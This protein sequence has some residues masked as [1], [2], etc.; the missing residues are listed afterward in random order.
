MKRNLMKM[1]TVMLSLVLVIGLFAGCGKDGGTAAGPVKDDGSVVIRVPF[2]SEPSSLD[3]GYGNSSD[4]IC[5]RGMMFEGLVRI[6]DNEVHPGMAESWEVADD[7]V[8]YTFHLRDSNW[9]DGEPVTA[10]DFVYGITR[11]LDPS[12]DAPNG[13]YAWMG[14]YIK[15]GEEFNSGECTAEELGIRAIDDKTLEITAVKNM[16]YFVELMKLPCFYPVREDMGEEYGKEYASSPDKVVCNGPFILTEWEHESKLVFEKNPEYWNA[17]AIN[18]DGV[19][20]Y[21]IGDT[22]TI[23]NMFDN[24]EL[25]IMNT[26]GKE[27]IDKYQES[28]EA[29]FIEG[30]TIWYTVVNTKTDRGEVSKLLQNKNFRQ[31]ISYVLNRDALVEAACGDGSFGITRMIPDLITVQDSTLGELYPYEP[32]STKGD[33]EKAQELFDKALEETGFT[34]DNLPD[35]TLLTFDDERAQDSAEIIQAQL[36]EAFGLNVIMDTQTYSARVEKEN[37]GDYDLCI[38]N[39]APDYN[40]P[41]TFLECYESNN[42]YNMYFGGLQNAEYDEIIAFCNATDDMKARADK[43]FEAEQM[44]VDEMVGIPLFQTAGYWGMKTYMSGIT[45]CGLGANDPDFSRVHYDGEE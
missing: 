28:D 34:R 16:P 2:A 33:A 27:Y 17:D 23:I 7:G 44:L 8:T 6:Y 29:V 5:P 11:L 3:P 35:I 14:Y 21:I 36:G 25:E 37:Q 31:A 26:I 22:E 10:H 20:A 24:G 40:D 9:S 38:T 45:K 12:E 4:S 15:N 43:M 13:N 32:Y 30:A 41:M 39:W 42:S 1:I 18:V 19:E